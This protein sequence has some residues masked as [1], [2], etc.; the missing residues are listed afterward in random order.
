MLLCALL[1]LE[2]PV[3]AGAGE[4]VAPPLPAGPACGDFLA[5]AGRK[6]DV[7]E[8]LGCEPGRD[9]QLPV[10]AALPEGSQICA[11][12]SKGPATGAPLR[13]GDKITVL[14]KAFSVIL[15]LD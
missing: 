1:A 12:Q 13:A 11:L 7:L 8:F 14:F 10:L 3:P 5:M 9:A 4:A 15:S 6:P 2:L